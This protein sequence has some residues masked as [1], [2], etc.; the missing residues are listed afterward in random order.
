[1]KYKPLPNG[2]IIKNSS[3]EGQGVFIT[4]DL[5]MGCKLGESHYRINDKLLT[6]S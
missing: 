3:I 1:M 2:L 6:I 4:K 5:S